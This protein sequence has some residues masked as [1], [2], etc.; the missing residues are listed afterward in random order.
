MMMAQ[1]DFVRA[2]HAYRRDRAMAQFGHP[3]GRRVRVPRRPS[4]HL[5]HPRRRP[6][7]LA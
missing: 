5:P 1:E 3:K 7:S 2:E 6:L 4:L